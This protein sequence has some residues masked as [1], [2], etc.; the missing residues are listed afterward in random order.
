MSA[1]T[2]YTALCEAILTDGNGLRI[3]ARGHSMYP[4]IRDGDDVRISPVLADD[5]RVGDI[6]CFRSQLEIVVVH[7]VIG[8]RS[9]EG[10][11]YF[12]MKGDLALVV[13]NVPAAA[14]LGLVVEVRRDERSW[15]LETPRAR[16]VARA[17]AL[18]SY[19]FTIIYLALV[20]AKNLV[21]RV[22][23]RRNDSR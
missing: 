5:V 1:L 4:V 13:E 7:R 8:I 6:L 3:R 15:S 2:P 23:G 17:L 12:R 14:V 11:L 21:L 18:G 9:I 22:F 19:P 20:K 10:K 16:M